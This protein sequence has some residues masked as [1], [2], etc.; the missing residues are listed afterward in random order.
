M[1]NNIERR[2]RQHNKHIKGGAR[3]TTRMITSHPET[4]WEP[5]VILSG[6]PDK[7]EAMKAEWRIRWPDKKRNKSLKFKLDTGRIAGIN[8]I[9]ENDTKWTES[10]QTIDTQNLTL[11]ISEEYRHLLNEDICLQKNITIMTL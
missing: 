1:T 5:M 11:K 2:F 7:S 6:F 8:H 9:L 10:S 4:K 3:A